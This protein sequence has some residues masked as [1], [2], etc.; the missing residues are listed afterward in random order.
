MALWFLFGMMAIAFAHL[1]W[2]TSGLMQAVTVEASGQMSAMHNLD[3]G[4]DGSRQTENSSALNGVWEQEIP[5]DLSGDWYSKFSINGNQL[6]HNDKSHI[7][8]DSTHNW[9]SLPSS[10]GG[11]KGTLHNNRITLDNGLVFQRKANECD[12][13]VM[14]CASCANVGGTKCV[15]CEEGLVLDNNSCQKCSTYAVSVCPSGGCAVTTNVCVA[16]QKCHDGFPD[17]DACS[18]SKVRDLTKVDHFCAGAACVIVDEDVCCKVPGDHKPCNNVFKSDDD[19]PAGMG[20]NLYNM[21]QACNTLGCS[22]VEHSADVALCC[23]SFVCVG[24][25]ALCCGTTR[26]FV[27]CF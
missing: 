22:K 2:E 25:H 5:G 19:C 4:G 17:D 11:G 1:D 27:A 13:T 16:L 20:V 9:F 8:S 14:G 23:K 26:R 12:S 18:G 15:E 10:M 6:S 24:T 21:A 3:V 7:L